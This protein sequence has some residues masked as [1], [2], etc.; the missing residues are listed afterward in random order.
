M[1]GKDT[2]SAEGG[3]RYNTRLSYS[4]STDAARKFADAVYSDVG[5]SIQP[6]P[7]GEVHRFNDSDGRRSNLACWYV[8]Y[9]VG[10]KI[11]YA[12]DDLDAY[13]ASLRVEPVAYSC[14]HGGEVV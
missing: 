13:L 2:S 9:K 12:I 3:N 11:M 7:D 4:T 10:K 6:I 5:A 1:D 8:L 14:T